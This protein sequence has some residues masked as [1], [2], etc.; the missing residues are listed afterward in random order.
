MV[1]L[2]FQDRLAKLHNNVAKETA[3]RKTLLDPTG[4]EK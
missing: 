3:R 2:S 1:V 4:A